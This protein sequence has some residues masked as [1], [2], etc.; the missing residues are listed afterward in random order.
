M[1]QQDVG[2]ISLHV[3]Q[4]PDNWSELLLL[5]EFP[6]NNAPSTMGIS[7]IFGNRGYHPN[8][9][10]HPECNLSSAQARDFVV[11]LDELHQELQLQI[12]KAQK[13]YQGPADAR[14]TLAPDFKVEDIVFVKAT[15]FCTTHPSKK[16]SENKLG[17]FEIIAKARP[18]SFT[19]TP[20]A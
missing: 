18:S 19:L 5:V 11:G 7:P 17:P 20:S 2:T 15:H 10:V 3:L 12:A 6:Y 13:C 16:L 14:Q 8:I 1:H 4:L 9:T